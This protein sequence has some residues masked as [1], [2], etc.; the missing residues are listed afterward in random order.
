MDS[1]AFTDI[2]ADFIRT[3]ETHP[4][5]VRDPERTRKHQQRN[6]K[7]HRSNNRGYPT[8]QQI[9]PEKTQPRSTHQ[10]MTPA[11]NA[12]NGVVFKDEARI[13]EAHRHQKIDM[14]N[15]GNRNQKGC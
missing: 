2:E 10:R 5:P 12:N 11:K 1:L 8:H 3:S 7:Q 15:I 14:E 6:T 9:N 4:E 13:V